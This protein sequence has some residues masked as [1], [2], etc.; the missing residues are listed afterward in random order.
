LKAD[1]MTAITQTAKLRE[2]RA[3]TDRQL[4]QLIHNRL[5][6]GLAFLA[7]AAD[8]PERARDIFLDNASNALSE[9]ARLLP[10]AGRIDWSTHTTLQVKMAQLR[11]GISDVALPDELVLT[12]PC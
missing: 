3:K 9:A 1:D 12:A 7:W 8:S 10:W 4:V 11:T 5:D 6:A 2:L